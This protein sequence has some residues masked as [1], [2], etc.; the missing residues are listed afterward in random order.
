MLNCVQL[1]CL[2]SGPG[3]GGLLS[4]HIM[5]ILWGSHA[6]NLLYTFSK[7]NRK[8]RASGNG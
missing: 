3:G 7:I 1:L 6:S 2:C 4:H 5:V 8:I